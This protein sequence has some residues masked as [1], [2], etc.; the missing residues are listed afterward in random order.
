MTRVFGKLGVASRAAVA[1][2][3]GR[4]RAD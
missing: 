2:I 4:E 3:V 1:E